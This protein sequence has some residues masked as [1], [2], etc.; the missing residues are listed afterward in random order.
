MAPNEK[1]GSSKPSVLG[2]FDPDRPIEN[3]E[4][5][6]LG[7]AEIAENL[8][9]SVVSNGARKGFVIGI[10]G[11]WG[12]GKSSILN[13]LAAHLRKVEDI[14]VLRFDPWVVGDRD[15]MVAALMGR[16]RGR[17]AKSWPG[18]QLRAYALS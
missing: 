17:D 18:A 8:A 15:S 16:V 1:G 10:E 3:P 12:S 5:D 7:F 6:R 13:L 4:A 9:K 14:T 2:S 11:K